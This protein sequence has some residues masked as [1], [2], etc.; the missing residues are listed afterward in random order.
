[1]ANPAIYA[2]YYARKGN[3]GKQFSQLNACFRGNRCESDLQ[4]NQRS[5]STA[6]KTCDLLLKK[7][8][9]TTPRMKASPLLLF[10][11]GVQVRSRDIFQ[12]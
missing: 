3:F 2:F 4:R 10:L 7:S 12:T 11:A 5:L 6:H 8:R 9:Q 1:M